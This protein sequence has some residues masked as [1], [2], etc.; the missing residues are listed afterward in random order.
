MKTTQL[1]QEAYELVKRER[2]KTGVAQYRI[3]SDAVKASLKQNEKKE[4]K[5]VFRTTTDV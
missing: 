4:I 3:V 5:N 1:D 2:Q